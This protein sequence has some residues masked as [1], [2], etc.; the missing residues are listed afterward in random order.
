M[1]KIDKDFLDNWKTYLDD[2]KDL[3]NHTLEISFG[4]EVGLTVIKN[5]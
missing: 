3:D 4:Q 5:N 2:N 1:T